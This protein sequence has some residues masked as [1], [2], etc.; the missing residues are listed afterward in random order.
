MKTILYYLL[1]IAAF[2]TTF[3][4]EASSKAPVR[5]NFSCVTLYPTTSFL[6][7]SAGNKVFIRLINHNG[8]KLMPIVSSPMTANDLPL[9]QHKAHLLSA[10]GKESLF[11]FDLKNCTHHKDGTLHCFGSYP[12]KGIETSAPYK[13][14]SIG[15]RFVNTKMYD[16]EISEIL[17]SAQ[18]QV[19]GESFD[20]TMPYSPEDCHFDIL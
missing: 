11:E 10:L 17:V 19:N 12:I 2:S 5:L 4:A 3:F 7:S 14:L 13:G 16:M 20:V 15:I 8:V 9:L 18:I 1:I 6:A